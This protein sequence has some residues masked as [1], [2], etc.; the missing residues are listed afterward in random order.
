MI[1]SGNL[2]Q[3]LGLVHLHSLF[4]SECAQIPFSLDRQGVERSKNSRSKKEAEDRLSAGLEKRDASGSG[5]ESVACWIEKREDLVDEEECDCD[6]DEADRFSDAGIPVS[7]T[8]LT[9][10]TILLV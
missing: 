5:D 3:I 4:V 6:Q 7:Y 9:L 2:S 1:R 8:H 10:P